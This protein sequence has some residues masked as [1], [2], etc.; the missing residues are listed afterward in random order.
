MKF[1]SAAKYGNSMHKNPGM[2]Y[3]TQ[4]SYGTQTSWPKSSQKA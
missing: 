1:E 2:S 4:S 3:D